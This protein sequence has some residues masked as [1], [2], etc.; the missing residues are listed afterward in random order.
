VND[1][2]KRTL[3]SLLACQGPVLLYIASQS[4][5]LG[6]NSTVDRILR[7]TC[8]ALSIVG[9]EMLRNLLGKQDKEIARLQNLVQQ[10]S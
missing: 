3:G 5:W 10:Q 1:K 2:T 6:L 8:A 7:T 4:G 9:A